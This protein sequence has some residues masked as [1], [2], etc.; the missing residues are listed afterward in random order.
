MDILGNNLAFLSGYQPELGYK[1]THFSPARIKISD[2]KK[3]DLMIEGLPFYGEDGTTA[4][5]KQVQHFLSQPTHF[6][7][8]YLSEPDNNSVHQTAINKI[9]GKV[10]QLDY[11]ENAK[12]YLSNLIILGSGLGFYLDLLMQD[13]AYANIILVEPDDEMLFHFLNHVN[14][15]EINQNCIKNGGRF[16]IIQ[17]FDSRSFSSMVR[18]VADEV[19]YGIFSEITLYRHYETPLFDNIIKHFK[20]IRGEWLSAWGFFDDEIAGIKHSFL[21]TDRHPVFISKRKDK[22]DNIK[23]LPAI[24]IGNGPS[25]DDNIDIIKKRQNDFIIISCGT[26][27]ASLIKAGISP[28]FHAEMERCDIT[29]KVQK[30]WYEHQLCRNTI[31]LSLN[32]VPPDIT[33]SFSTG[34]LFTKANDIGAYLLE[35]GNKSALTPLY[36]CN[37]TVTNFAAS[38]AIAI[39][40]ES[41]ILIGCDYGFRHHDCHHSKDSDYYNPNSI[42]SRFH[43]DSEF[44]VPDNNGKSI[45]TNRILNQSRK[46]MEKLIQR[47]SNVRVINCS[48]GAFIEGSEALELAQIN[49]PATS[50]SSTLNRTTENNLT[51]IESKDI[52]SALT[53]YSKSISELK[54]LISRHQ[55]C[56][57]LNILFEKIMSW[58]KQKN[59]KD[60]IDIILSGTINYL[61]VCTAGH[62]ARIPPQQRKEYID[63]TI[64]VMDEMFERMLS[65][66]NEIAKGSDK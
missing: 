46:T 5:Y 26:A 52:C 41:I 33:T 27:L 53:F 19:G 44:S 8:K 51:T 10:R 11:R 42:L 7:L 60:H 4:C 37:P 61:S 48:D 55:N 30:K 35:K 63:F 20:E 15:E 25:L 66:L 13:M 6:S 31:L 12:P 38:A 45:F 28:D 22:E 62:L 39:G 14:L 2:R 24:I 49:T 40:L 47:N 54:A 43:H 1:F 65:E 16:C 57:Q 59:R 17:P 29:P 21:N 32:T 64:S 36:F 58:F 34:I 56:L 50:K 18:N 3:N 23:Q 9:N